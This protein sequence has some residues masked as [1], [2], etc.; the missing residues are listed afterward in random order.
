MKRTDK[1]WCL[2]F[3]RRGGS[4]A[5]ISLRR[6]IPYLCIQASFGAAAQSFHGLFLEIADHLAGCRWLRGLFEKNLV[7]SGQ[8]DVAEFINETLEWCRSPL[9]S[10]SWERRYNAVD[11]CLCA[12]KGHSLQPVALTHLF[13]LGEPKQTLEALL[14]HGCTVME[15]SPLFVLTVA[16]RS[17]T[18]TD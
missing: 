8:R 16:P 6:T 7:E 17:F 2:C 11:E 1:G 9:I 4:P 12:D 14:L 5:L 15:W 10:M 3:P 13:E 18:Q